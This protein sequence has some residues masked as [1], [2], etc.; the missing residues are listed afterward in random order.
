[1]KLSILGIAYIKPCRGDPAVVSKFSKGW[2]DRLILGDMYPLLKLFST[3]LYYTIPF[4]FHLGCKLVDEELR[5]VHIV[6]LNYFTLSLELLTA[7]DPKGCY[8]SC[9]S[10]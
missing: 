10:K 2:K 3:L 5:N 7:N 6:K 9:A 1:M 4:S 8:F